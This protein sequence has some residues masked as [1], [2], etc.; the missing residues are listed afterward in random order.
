[1]SNSFVE[2]KY[3]KQD[4]DKMVEKM[5]KSL[6]AIRTRKAKYEDVPSM[7]ARPLRNKNTSREHYIN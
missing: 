1:M 4:H 6:E 5:E 7:A 3:F 2:S